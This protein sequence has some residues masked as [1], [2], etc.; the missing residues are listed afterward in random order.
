M[1]TIEH[2]DDGGCFRLLDDGIGLCTSKSR[3]VLVRVRDALN[4]IRETG[5]VG[6]TVKQVKDTIPNRV[7]G[8]PRGVVLALVSGPPQFVVRRPDNKLDIWPVIDCVVVE[9]EP[10]EKETPSNEP[11]IGVRTAVTLLER[12]LSCEREVSIDSDLVRDTNKFLADRRAA[13]PVP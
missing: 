2:D 9:P 6:L 5:L 8:Y 3:N 11:P 4:A 12:F 7:D 10:P 13:E 1:L